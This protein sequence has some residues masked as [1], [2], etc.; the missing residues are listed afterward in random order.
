MIMHTFAGLGVLAALSPLAAQNVSEGVLVGTPAAVFVE[1]GTHQG[2]TPLADNLLYRRTAGFSSLLPEVIPSSANEPEFTTTAIFGDGF[3]PPPFRINAL[4]I[5]L[6][7]VLSDPPVAGEALVN[8][9]VGAWGALLFSVTRTSMGAP[10]SLIESE[11]LGP[12]GVGADLFSMMLPG[13]SLPP[14]VAGCYPTDRFQRAVDALETG[15]DPFPLGD[16]TAGDFYIP[17][18]ETGAPVRATLPDT[19]LVFFSIHKADIFPSTGPSPV[20]SGWFGT[21]TPSPATILVT[22]WNRV[23]SS[24]STPVVHI[25]YNNLGLA[26]DDDVDALAVDFDDEILLFSIAKTANSTLDEQLQ[27]AYWGSH[28]SF[29]GG[30][31]SASTGNYVHDDGEGGTESVVR[32]GGAGETDDVNLT[33]TIDP[34]EMGDPLS[35]S[36]S[37]PAGKVTPFKF[38]PG[39]IFRDEDSA[40]PTI[41]LTG[42]NI[43][44]G[45]TFPLETLEIWLGAPLGGTGYFLFPFPLY[46]EFLN[47]TNPQSTRAISFSDPSLAIVMGVEIDLF[48]VIR[49]GGIKLSSAMLRLRI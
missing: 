32:T 13:S 23:T 2:T 20:P 21:T 46:S 36:I 49:G 6:D 48:W 43:P 1:M 27:I 19:P 16:L 30:G 7:V 11:R 42:T 40:G 28:D 18:Y 3:A 31:T 26:V 5:G 47:G 12:G 45:P 17:L 34:G 44:T 9:P 4:S 33:C 24:W 22:Q 38:I 35:L 10:G 41:T 8:V 15:I 37:T 39:S 25:A 29:L 14:T